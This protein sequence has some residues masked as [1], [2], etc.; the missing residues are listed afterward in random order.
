MEMVLEVD[1]I[2]EETKKYREKYSDYTK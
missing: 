1:D 2:I